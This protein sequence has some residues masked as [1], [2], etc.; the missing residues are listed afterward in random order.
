MEE[1]ITVRGQQKCENRIWHP[2][3]PSKGSLKGLIL[4]VI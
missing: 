4:L 2:Y 1:F 3:T